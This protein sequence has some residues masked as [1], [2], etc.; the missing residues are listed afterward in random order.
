MSLNSVSGNAFLAKINGQYE[1]NQKSKESA[2]N[3]FAGNLEE[4][5]K[6][7]IEEEAQENVTENQRTTQ[8]NYRYGKLAT[9]LL[10]QK[11]GR[12]Q[13]HGVMETGVRQISYSESDYVKVCATEGYTLKA[14]VD[15]TGHS[16]YIEQKNEDGTYLAYE[17]NPLQISKD[18]DNP[19]EQMALEAWELTREL[20]NDGMFTELEEESINGT[21]PAVSKAAEE[22]TE[23]NAVS[24]EEMVEQF[25][26]FVK[27]R[28]KEGPPKIQIGGAEFSE[29]EW[30]RLLKKVD[31]D[32]DAYKEVSR[33]SSFLA[34]LSGEKKAPYSYLAD[35][36]GTIVYKGVTFV[37]DDKKQQICLGDMSDKKNVLK[38][39]LS[40]GGCLCVN[41]ENLDDLAK[42]IDMFSPEDINRIMRAIAQDTKVKEM[43]L[44]KFFSDI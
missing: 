21:K 36:T 8:I 34:R 11:T 31:K 14:Q 3:S 16:V 19:V 30:K 20:V 4:K 27:Q 39:P 44:E 15:M 18:T 38:I 25:E 22:E 37:C 41:R 17:V 40:K 6:K 10:L 29:E 5:T 26:A 1:K 7:G 23:E 42:A 2:Y 33:G 24:F 28:I 32:I 43:E 35:E 9:E 13:V 12:V